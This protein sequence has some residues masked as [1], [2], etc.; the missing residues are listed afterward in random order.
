MRR[1]CCSGS[2]SATP[3]LS[4][5]RPAQALRHAR[6]GRR[7]GRRDHRLRDATMPASARPTRASATGSTRRWRSI[8]ASKMS[9][10]R[11]AMR[12]PTSSTNRTMSRLGRSSGGGSTPPPF[13]V[14]TSGLGGRG[15]TVVFTGKLVTLSR[16]EAKAQAERLG[17]KVGGLGL[18]GDRSR[19]RRCRCGIEAQEGAG[20]G[21]PH[22][23]RRGMGGDRRAG[24]VAVPRRRSGSRPH[25]AIVRCASILVRAW[26]PGSRRGTVKRCRA[27]RIFRITRYRVRMADHAFDHPPHGRRRR[28]DRAAG[29]GG[30]TRRR[31]RDRPCSRASRIA[32][33]ARRPRPSC[34][35]RRAAPLQARDSGLRRAFRSG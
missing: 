35:A 28:L 33:G 24:G 10:L 9:A 32:G 34:A 15:Q 16:D 19:R 11:S 18:E 29:L 8:S 12:S 25:L 31:P 22:R 2:A 6:R 7:A 3:A 21:R 23:D 4:R 5:A 30:Y 14:E 27:T 1:G 20:S 17:A 13:V 26:A